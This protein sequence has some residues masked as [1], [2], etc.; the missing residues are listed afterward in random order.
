VRC[1]ALLALGVAGCLALAPTAAAGPARAATTSCAALA[2][3]SWLK[4]ELFARFREGAE[5]PSS[6]RLR[7]F[8]G[9]KYGR[10][11]GTR[12]AWGLPV[13]ASG[14]QLTEREAVSTQDHSPLWERRAGHLWG[15]YGVG[16]LC[17]PGRLPRAMAHAWHLNVD[18]S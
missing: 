7:M 18:C 11:G 1:R 3:P 16:P 5:L 13:L 2:V 17:G 10:C 15:E 12:W 8:E 14:Q 4:G 9:L 6:V